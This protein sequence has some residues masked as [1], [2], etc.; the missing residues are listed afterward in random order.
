MIRAIQLGVAY[1]VL[2]VATAGQVQASF[3]T[4]FGD[5][6][7]AIP[8]G[9]QVDFESGPSATLSS[10]ADSGVTI[11]GIGGPIR[12]NANYS[13]LYNMTGRHADNNGGSTTAGFLFDFD[14]LVDAFAFNFGATNANWTLSAFDQNGNLIESYAVPLTDGSNAGEFF[15]IQASGIA[16]ITLTHSGGDWVLLDNFTFS[17]QSV[18]A[19]PEPSSLAIFGICACVAGVGSARRRR[20]EKQQEVTA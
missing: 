7:S 10:Y 9:T 12:I 14:H 16:T 20:R 11:S 15:G 17:E 19:V 3:I 18:A 13:G 4:G 8:G 6:L 2:L 5:P 1:V